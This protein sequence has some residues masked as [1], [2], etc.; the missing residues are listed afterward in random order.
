MNDPNSAD[1]LP[2]GIAVSV[3]FDY[4]IDAHF[5]QTQTHTLGFFNLKELI[6]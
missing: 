4:G 3:G 6:N 5:K 2:N 1:Q